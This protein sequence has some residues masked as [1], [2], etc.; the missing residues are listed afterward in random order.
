LSDVK[1][2][3]DEGGLE[4]Q[5]ALNKARKLR[6]MQDLKPKKHIESVRNY[7]KNICNWILLL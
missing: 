1:L 2:E 7:L 3:P 5:L 6:Q 4:L